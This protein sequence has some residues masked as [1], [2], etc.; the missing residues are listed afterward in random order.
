MNYGL[1]S[2]NRG[3]STVFILLRTV[4]LIKQRMNQTDVNL[5]SVPQGERGAEPSRY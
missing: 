5:P 4:N 2:G 1:I 3:F